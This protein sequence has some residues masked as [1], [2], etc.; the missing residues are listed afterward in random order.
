MTLL[1]N[2][3]IFS[4]APSYFYLLYTYSFGDAIIISHGI[5]QAKKQPRERE[6]EITAAPEEK[7]AS[8]ARARTKSRVVP[9]FYRFSEGMN[10]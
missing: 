8:K 6:R 3:S 7:P 9:Y 1:K 2:V 5:R 10:I 4:S